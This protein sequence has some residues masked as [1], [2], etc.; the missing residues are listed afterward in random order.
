MN[1]A[2]PPPAEPDSAH[3]TVLEALTS[4]L[5]AVPKLSLKDEGVKWM[6]SHELTVPQQSDLARYRDEALIVLG[7]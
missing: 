3:L 1:D 2:A 5:G 7:G 6:E 4:K